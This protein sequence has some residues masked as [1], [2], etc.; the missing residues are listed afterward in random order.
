MRSGEDRYGHACRVDH[1]IYRRTRAI[2]RHRAHR[3]HRTRALRPRR[4]ET[5]RRDDRQS[6]HQQH[7]ICGCLH[8]G[9]QSHPCGGQQHRCLMRRQHRRH[10][11]RHRCRRASVCIL[12]FLPDP[13]RN[14]S[15]SRFG[16]GTRDREK[17]DRS[18]SW[19][20]QHRERDRRWHDGYLHTAAQRAA[21][22]PSAMY[23]TRFV[24]PQA[25]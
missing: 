13:R 6:H 23:P 14:S 12:P 17:D 2:K 10:R 16:V 4:E 24:R 25:G 3:I 7:Q 21:S 22:S 20:D 5:D 18:A 15:G 11:H 1:R 8:A 19:I 9:T